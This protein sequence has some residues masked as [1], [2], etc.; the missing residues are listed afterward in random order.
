MDLG[1]TTWRAIEIT[2][3]GWEVV[4][5]P[6][7]HFIRDA[8]TQA[9]PE[10]VPGGS[11]EELRQFANCADEGSWIRLC[12]F[13]VMCFHPQG[14]YPVAYPT[15]EQGS[16]KS[17]LSRLICSLVDPRVAPLSMGGQSIRDLA[18]LANSVWLAAFD[19]V[20][21]VSPA[22]AD[23]L[24]QLST[25]GGYR[26]RKLYSDGETSSSTSGALFC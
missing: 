8:T 19:N 24:C 25:G 5:N 10:P 12:G 2:R 11:I 6:D 3:E 14:P 18:V 21:K 20:S 22:F 16:A 23:G 7:V 9:L 13:L 1:D 4:E 26:T 17:T 15:G